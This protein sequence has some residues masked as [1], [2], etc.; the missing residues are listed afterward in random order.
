MWEE[1]PFPASILRP[2]SPSARCTC[3]HWILCGCGCHGRYCDAS[4][5]TCDPAFFP[6]EGGLTTVG[7]PACTPGQEVPH[8]LGCELIGWSVPLADALEPARKSRRRPVAR[9]VRQSLL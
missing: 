3:E 5:L 9:L 6:D 4:E 1:R 2:P 8:M 7:C